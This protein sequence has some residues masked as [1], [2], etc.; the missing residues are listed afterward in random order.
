MTSRLSSARKRGRR[1]LNKNVTTSS[2]YPTQRAVVAAKHIHQACG[3]WPNDGHT[4]VDDETHGDDDDDVADSEV[5]EANSEP[6]DEIIALGLPKN[7]SRDKGD[8]QSEDHEV[9]VETKLVLSKNDITRQEMGPLRSKSTSQPKIR[10]ISLN[11]NSEQAQVNGQSGADLSRSNSNS[12]AAESGARPQR[13]L[14]KPSRLIHVTPRSSVC[15]SGGSEEDN[16]TYFAPETSQESKS[17][18]QPQ[19]P[20]NFSTP[21]PLPAITSPVILPRFTTPQS[22][23][24]S[25]PRSGSQPSSTP[26][27]TSQSSSDPHAQA[28]SQP[29]LS[30]GTSLTSQTYQ[31]SQQQPDRWP[32]ASTSWTSHALDSRLA[33][34]QPSTPRSN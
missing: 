19:A 29:T 32:P 26:A 30:C 16:S 2:D 8:K 22:A 28:S 7:R 31:S 20:P 3:K 27:S 13:R 9:T 24:Q 10:R 21:S 12:T 34:S 1:S 14:Q 23:L 25:G 4:P 18:T 15:R 33:G 6:A 11:Q 17:S 5:I